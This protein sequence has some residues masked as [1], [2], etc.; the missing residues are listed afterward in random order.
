MVTPMRDS[1]WSV[2]GPWGAGLNDT[3]ASGDIK[4][5]DRICTLH[6]LVT[7]CIDDN[8]DLFKA[9]V[10]LGY[11]FNPIHVCLCPELQWRCTVMM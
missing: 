4:G 7:L 9:G 1:T 3:N 5:S 6:T 2:N 8:I 11:L 10:G